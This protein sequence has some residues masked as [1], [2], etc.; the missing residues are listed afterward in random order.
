MFNK[1]I[2]EVRH[3]LTDTL[4]EQVTQY[5]RKKEC[6][7][8]FDSSDWQK[9]F[10][11]KKILKHLIGS[12]SLCHFFRV[13]ETQQD[14]LILLVGIDHALAHQE[15][16]EMTRKAMRHHD[17]KFNQAMRCKTRIEEK[18]IILEKQIKRRT[19]EY[20]QENEQLIQ[21]YRDLLFSNIE[22]HFIFSEYERTEVFDPNNPHHFFKTAGHA[23]RY[24]AKHARGEL[25]L[26]RYT[27]SYHFVA[28]R[29][30][31]A[32][33]RICHPLVHQYAKRW[34]RDMEK[35]EDRLFQYPRYNLFNLDQLELC[36]QQIANTHQFFREMQQEEESIH[37]RFRTRTLFKQ[38]LKDT[39]DSFKR[40][41]LLHE[42]SEERFLPP[43][44]FDF[45]TYPTKLSRA[46][47]LF[48]EF[49]NRIQSMRRRLG[50]LHEEQAELKEE[51]QKQ[52]DKLNKI[53]IQQTTTAELQRALNDTPSN[54]TATLFIHKIEKLIE[55]L[56]KLNKNKTHAFITEHFL[57]RITSIRDSFSDADLKFSN[58]TLLLGYL[59]SQISMLLPSH[60]I[61]HTFSDYEAAYLSYIRSADNNI[62][63]PEFKLLRAFDRFLLKVSRHCVVHEKSSAPSTPPSTLA[64]QQST[65]LRPTILPQEE[66]EESNSQLSLD[67][68]SSYTST[69]SESMPPEREDAERRLSLYFIEEASQRNRGKSGRTGTYSSAPLDVISRTP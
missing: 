34:C 45:F 35:E 56:S 19:R 59:H 12:S 30:D 64:S 29:W 27:L 68:A 16:K 15:K 4:Q 9:I 40:E 63:E 38:L 60:D 61:D 32:Y 21:T 42:G 65:P 22:A 11:S 20:H 13:V 7:T 14:Y 49:E 23:L 66:D 8:H 1:K 44:K 36:I 58:P 50:T 37:Q 6:K 67:I 17:E 51:H 53:I 26:G 57:P 43:V 69:E 33:E 47:P 54:H 31:N 24:A 48:R 10:V 55:Q 52:I 5:L 39:I 2:K 46:I 3:P 62:L 41:H 25:T 18:L 28:R